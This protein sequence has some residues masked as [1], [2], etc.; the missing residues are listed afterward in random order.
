MSVLENK[1]DNPLNVVRNSYGRRR[2]FIDMR[3]NPCMIYLN[4]DIS[5]KIVFAQ[6][7]KVSLDTAAKPYYQ[8]DFGGAL[9]TET[10]LASG[11]KSN[12]VQVTQGAG[13]SV[14]VP[15]RFL[16]DHIPQNFKLSIYGDGEPASLVTLGGDGAQI[17]IQYEFIAQ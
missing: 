12:C 7:R 16:S 14:R 3:T 17:F 10:N 1:Q 15:I 13:E 9:H 8:L 11:A 6:I 5:G 2:I 4:S